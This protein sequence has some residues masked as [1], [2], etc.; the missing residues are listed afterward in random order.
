MTFR[1]YGR[2]LAVSFIP[3]MLIG[4]LVFGFF[5]PFEQYDNILCEYDFGSE[6][7]RNAGGSE[8]NFYKSV[9]NS[10]KAWFDIGLKPNT[11]ANHQN[12]S[13]YFALQGSSLYL[14]GGQIVDARSY[15]GISAAS[16]QLVKSLIGKPANAQFGIEGHKNSIV[17]TDGVILYCNAVDFT[18]DPNLY[19]A[20]CGGDGWNGIFYLSFISSSKL[21]LDEM[22][23]SI[24]RAMD[25]TNAEYFQYRLITYPLFVYIFLI[26]SALFWTVRKAIGFV[27]AG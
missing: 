3:L 6:H 14:E 25:R 22:E 27:N 9:K 18:E 17:M 8:N 24:L 7:C 12:S 4:Y 16:E 26:L 21:H 20:S 5:V 10:H 15:P 1:K 11:G 13:I 2:L 23:S 19:R